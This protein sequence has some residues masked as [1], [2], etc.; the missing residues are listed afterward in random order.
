MNNEKSQMDHLLSLLRPLM[1]TLKPNNRDKFW[2]KNRRDLDSI[3]WT[4]KYI[5]SDSEESDQEEEDRKDTSDA[6]NESRWE[7]IDDHAEHRSAKS[8]MLDSSK[9]SNILTEDERDDYYHNSSSADYWNNVYFPNH[10]DTSEVADGDDGE[11]NVFDV[12]KFP[13]DTGVEWLVALL[14]LAVVQ[15]GVW[16]IVSMMQ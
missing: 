6:P 13:E 5:F 1:P 7:H 8:P 10:R 2:S 16:W 4:G 12:E 3:G 15:G 11:E 9:T 14:F